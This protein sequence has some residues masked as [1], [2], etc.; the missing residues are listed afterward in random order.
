MAGTWY[1]EIDVTQEPF[2]MGLDGQ[3]RAR[4]GF[5]LIAWKR[6]S[7]TFIRELMKL[8]QDASVG[9]M[10]VD[11]FGST[12]SFVP[13]GDGPFINVSTTGGLRHIRTQNSVIVPAYQRPSVQIVARA[14]Q[15]EA[16][17]AM[18][19]KAYNA[20]VGIRNQGVTAA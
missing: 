20:L 2:D 13:E 16:A 9:S 7:E 18:A 5:N 1:V 14:R 19:W 4:S 11:I 10:G 3:S 17:D 12:R 15:W 8:L 6:P